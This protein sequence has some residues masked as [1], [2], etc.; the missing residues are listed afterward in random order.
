MDME[1]L[2]DKK[3]EV[4]LSEDGVANDIMKITFPENK[5]TPVH[6]L[7]LEVYNQKDSIIANTF[8]WRSTNSYKGPWTV[9]GPLQGGFESLSQLKTSYLNSQLTF[10]DKGDRRYYT[11]RLCNKS[12]SL[13]FFNRLMLTDSN[14]GEIIHPVFYSDNYFSMLPGENKTITIDVSLQDIH[15]HPSEIILEGYNVKRK[16]LK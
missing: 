16:V 11:V 15:L 13:A 7:K 10:K 3:V 2:M 8:Y 4:N 6:F 9:G 12:F 1:T 14:T 5:L